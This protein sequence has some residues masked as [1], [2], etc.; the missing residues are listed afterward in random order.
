MSEIIPPGNESSVESY[1]GFLMQADMTEGAVSD[2]MDKYKDI[3]D[4]WR[5]K[6]ISDEVAKEE[7]LE[8]ARGR[9][10]NVH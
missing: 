8:I 1:I 9:G 7:A 10:A 6:E 2:E 5:K 4:R 3:L